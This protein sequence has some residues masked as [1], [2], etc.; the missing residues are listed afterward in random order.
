MTLNWNEAVI[1]SNYAVRMVNYV[2]TQSL[3]GMEWSM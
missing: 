2:N 1:F 3:F